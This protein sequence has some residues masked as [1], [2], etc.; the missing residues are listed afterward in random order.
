MEQRIANGL[1]FRKRYDVLSGKDVAKLIEEIFK[2]RNPLTDAQKECLYATLGDVGY[3]GNLNMPFQAYK[4]GCNPC[5]PKTI[6]QRISILLVIFICIILGLTVCPIKW[7][8]TGEY[9]INVHDKYFKWL[10]NFY[11]FALGEII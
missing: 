7:F 4:W 11:T 5:H 2:N 8:L 9:A 3:Y 6:L 10:Y 1:I